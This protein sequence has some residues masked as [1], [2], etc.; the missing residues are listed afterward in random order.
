MFAG[1]SITPGIFVWVEDSKVVGFSAADPRNGNIFALFVEE[2]YEG[3]GIAR[4]LFERACNV[5]DEAG[6]PRIWL[7]TWPGTRAERFYR[8]AGWQVT[9]S[10]DG[11][12][13]FEKTRSPIRVIAVDP[14]R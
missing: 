3:R 12:L 6:C 8:K 13:V 1:S 5:L 7:T 14:P 2:A 9:G 10:H 4:A 11:N